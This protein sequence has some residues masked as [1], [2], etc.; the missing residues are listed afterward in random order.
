VTSAQRLTGRITIDLPPGE[1][2]RLFAP[3]GERDWVS[4]WD[5]HFPAPAS[6]DTEPGTVFETHVHDQ[7][8]VWVVSGRE[9]GRRI[10]YA[11]VTPGHL[12]G[13]VAISIRPSGRQSEVQVTYQLTALTPTAS[14]KLKAEAR[15]ALWATI[16]PTA[17][18]SGTAR[19]RR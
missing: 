10:S 19:S 14:Q 9:P 5:P 13:T 18:P 8:T 1:A 3:R 7:H 15:D 17:S 4:G 16:S 6:D 12:A 11:R 2:F